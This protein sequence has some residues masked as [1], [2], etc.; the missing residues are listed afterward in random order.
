MESVQSTCVH[1]GPQLQT[2]YQ[3]DNQNT[4]CS[5]GHGPSCEMTY[6]PCP[7]YPP[8]APSDSPPHFRSHQP[9]VHYGS[10]KS[11]Y[12]SKDMANLCT[13]CK[14][15][16]VLVVEKDSPA[17]GS[18]STKVSDNSR[19]CLDLKVSHSL[20][21]LSCKPLGSLL[22]AYVMLIFTLVNAKCIYS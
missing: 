7:H 20:L 5:H 8:G 17:L 10:V 19:N 9:H 22:C 16:F 18:S 3:S 13:L 21:G 2:K 11:K 4:T 6:L 12:L 1:T 15:A 14:S